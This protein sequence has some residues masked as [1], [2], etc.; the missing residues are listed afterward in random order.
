LRRVLSYRREEGNSIVEEY[1]SDHINDCIDL[2]KGLRSSRIGRAG[3]SLDP[4]FPDA[5]RLSA[6]FHDLGKAF[7]RARGGG[8][9]SFVGHEILSAYLLREFQWNLLKRGDGDSEGLS[10]S[11]TP[12]LFAVAFHH[13]PMGI[14]ERLKGIER[15]ELSPGPLEDLLGELSLLREGALGAEEGRL[16]VSTLEAVKRRMCE[17][18]LRAKDIRRQFSHKIEAM[19][20][21]LFSSLER[22]GPALK[23]LSN[24]AL[25]ALISADYISA[26][27]RRGGRVARFGEVLEEFHA[28]YLG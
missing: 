1:L 27:R 5:V 12:A 19:F 16:L 15:A 10:R 13:H 18:A 22:E 17:G 25:A 20:F 26:R 24:M 21:D 28:L 23:R 3:I 7:Y 8:P 2:L 11:L 6:V 9:A 4:G 14:G